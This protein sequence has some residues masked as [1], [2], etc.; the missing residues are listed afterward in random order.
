MEVNELKR[1]LK[2]SLCRKSFKEF[3]NFYL[4]DII[5]YQYFNIQLNGSFKMDPEVKKIIEDFID[6]N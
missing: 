3:W 1:K 4:K 2:E 6:V 5:S